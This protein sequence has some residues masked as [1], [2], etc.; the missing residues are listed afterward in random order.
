MSVKRENLILPFNAPD[1]VDYTDGE[2]KFVQADGTY[3]TA[4]ADGF[5][6]IT[7]VV[8]AKLASVAVRGFAGAVGVKLA[9]GVLPQRG[10]YLAAGAAGATIGTG[11]ADS[12]ALALGPNEGDDVAEAVLLAPS[13]TITIE[14]PTQ[15]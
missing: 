6:V 3:A 2:G 1:G 4:S 8:S 14:A 11:P 5:G 7:D 10:D 9:A 12:V 15:G 13:V